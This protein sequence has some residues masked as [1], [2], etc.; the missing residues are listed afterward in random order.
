M[1]AHMG[2]HTRWSLAQGGASACALPLA[3]A[4]ITWYLTYLG[5]LTFAV[6][7]MACW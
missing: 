1:H 3:P 4:L 5:R 2:K 7:Y 6:P